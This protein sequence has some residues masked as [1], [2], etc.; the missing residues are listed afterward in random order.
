MGML[1]KLRNQFNFGLKPWCV[2]VNCWGWQRY[3][4]C[5]EGV[6]FFVV[7]FV[8][9]CRYVISKWNSGKCHGLVLKLALCSMCGWVCSPLTLSPLTVWRPI[10]PLTLKHECS[11]PL[12]QQSG[13]C[14]TKRDHWPHLT[15]HCGNDF[16]VIPAHLIRGAQRCTRWPVMPTGISLLSDAEQWC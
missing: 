3:L 7:V 13:Y 6:G 9:G 11:L 5:F 15:L 16:P 12:S 4:S 10:N 2:Q 1:A 14:S 8:C